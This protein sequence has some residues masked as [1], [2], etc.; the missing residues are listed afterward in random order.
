MTLERDRVARRGNRVARRTPPPAA[1]TARRTPRLPPWLRPE[2]RARLGRFRREVRTA[3]GDRLLDLQ[4]FGSRARDEGHPRSDLDVLVFVRRRNRRDARRVHE[5]SCRILRDDG[6][7]EAGE[8]DA[9]VI[10]LAQWR[11]LLDRELLFGREVLRDG[12]PL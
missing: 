7:P 2:E 3:L 10:D 11:F 12:I 8:I 5:I 4:L 9:I 6:F 1:R